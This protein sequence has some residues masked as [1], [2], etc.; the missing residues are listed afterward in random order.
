MSPEPTTRNRPIRIT[1]SYRALATA[2]AACLSLGVA[3]CGSDEPTAEEDFCEAGDSLQTDINALTDVDLISEGTD[4]LKG[5]FS[6]NK[7]DLDQLRESG[8]DVASDEISALETAVNDFGAAVDA[9]GD[10]I[11]VEG[12][13][14]AGTALTG[15]TTAANG[16]FDKLSSTCD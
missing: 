14:T 3:A 7:A 6:T 2:F 12:A 8:S 9:L 15:I 10:D 5:R 11:S 13:K 4:P 16:V 1:T